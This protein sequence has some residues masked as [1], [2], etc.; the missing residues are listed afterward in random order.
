MRNSKLWCYGHTQ[1]MLWH[2]TSSCIPHFSTILANTCTSSQGITYVD[3]IWWIFD[4]LV[5]PWQPLSRGATVYCVAPWRRP[6]SFEVSTLCATAVSLSSPAGCSSGAWKVNLGIIPLGNQPIKSLPYL[7]RAFH[8]TGMVQN[9]K[10]K[11]LSSGLLWKGSVYVSSLS[12]SCLMWD[13]C[14]FLAK[15][16]K[17][18]QSQGKSLFVE[19][20]PAI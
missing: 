14:P 8:F 10:H 6:A 7:I 17:L 11:W 3:C 5:L 16:R 13:N 15:V 12:S 1:L 20:I 9:G 19:C 2:R 4:W 18:S